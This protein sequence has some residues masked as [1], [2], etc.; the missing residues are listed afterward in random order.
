MK[1]WSYEAVARNG[2][3]IKGD[4][5]A[6]SKQE[7]I[8]LLQD[9]GLTV[10]HVAEGA[11]I[12]FKRLLNFNIGGIG[13]ND[14]V[15]F[16]KQFST[17]VTAGLP[18][19]E[20]LETLAT[21]IKNPGMRTVVETVL[22][23][24]KSGVSLTNAFKKTKGLFDDIQINLIEAGEKSGNLIDMIA[25][26]SKDL[27]QRKN[28]VSKVRGAMIYPII[29]FTAVFLIM[30]LLMMTMVPA[31]ETLFKGFKAE[32]KIPWITVAMINTANFLNPAKSVGGILI[33]V[34]VVAIV[35]AIKAYRKT[36]SGRRVTDRVLLRVPIF[37]GLTS[38]LNTEEFCRILAM[39]LVSGVS[40]ID[41]LKI[42]AGAMSN[43]IY[44]D[45]VMNMIP[46]IE[47]GFPVAAPMIKD[48][49]FPN[50]LSRMVGTGEQ[51]GKLD[52][53]LLDMAK[54]YEE[55]IEN[56]T[57]NLTKLMEPIILIIVGVFVGIMAV[58][59]YLPIYQLATV[60]K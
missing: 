10:V 59:I 17:M 44:R 26:I 3:Q 39:L 53:V 47:K 34:V 36:P 37:G 32:D 5:E 29:I 55:E 6:I 33:V 23:D 1:V 25:K 52:K 40:I 48:N 57:A 24:V 4:I 2:K 19:T 51:T 43:V 7:V 11:R 9:Q 46:Q 27:D 60:V 42:V 13:L 28:F 14:R 22:K 49:V 18:I 15:I 50:I 16:M 45:A 20:A 31:V 21:Q 8:S 54:Y 12:T 41:S 56:I 35:F 58:A 30:I 38:K